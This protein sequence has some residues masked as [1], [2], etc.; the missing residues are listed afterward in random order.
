MNLYS[1]Q[2]A[3]P[4]TFPSPESEH[5]GTL[6]VVAL[7]HKDTLHPFCSLSRCTFLEFSCHM[8]GSPTSHEKAVHMEKNQHLQAESLVQQSGHGQQQLASIV[9]MLSFMWISRGALLAQSVKCRHLISALVMI[10]HL[11]DQAPPWALSGCGVCLGFSLSRVEFRWWSS[12][13]TLS[14]SC[15]WNTASSASTHLN[16]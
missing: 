7:C 8:W 12:I 13:G 10:S 6:R 16:A 11:W 15:P 3:V 9:R 2:Q 4:S 14:L 1:F 5:A